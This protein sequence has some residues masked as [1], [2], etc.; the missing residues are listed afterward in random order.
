MPR[1]RELSDPARGRDARQVAQPRLGSLWHDHWP[2][3]PAA[4]PGDFRQ[5]FE[6]RRTRPGRRGPE[7]RR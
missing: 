7:E 6:A 4:Q 5:G 2:Q 3:G 1:E